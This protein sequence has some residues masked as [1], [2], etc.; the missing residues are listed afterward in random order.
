MIHAELFQPGQVVDRTK[1]ERLVG[2]AG[3]ANGTGLR[4]FHDGARP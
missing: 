3:L 2:R 1:V 4:K